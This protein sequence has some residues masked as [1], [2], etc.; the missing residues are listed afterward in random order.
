M[1]LSAQLKE[2]LKGPKSLFVGTRDKDFNC[3]ALRVL[4]GGSSGHDTIK[5]FIA[6]KTAGKTLDNMR[7][8]KLVSL[9]VTN[10]FTSESYQFKGR[11][12]S[13]RATN[14]EEAN[15]VL[16]YVGQFE[17][18]VSGMGY[19]KGLVADHILYKPALA[20]EFVVDQIFEQTPKVGTGQKLTTV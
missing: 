13:A 2:H 11:F 20:I 17:E 19:P 10:I 4:G 1:I 3:D 8:N 14:E 12:L 15:A 7:A 18:A 16:E 6:E 9:S 5:F